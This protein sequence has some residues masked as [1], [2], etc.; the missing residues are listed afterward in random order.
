MLPLIALAGVIGAV[1]SVAKGAAWA[2]DQVDSTKGAASVGGKGGAKTQIDAKS[3]PFADALAAQ[4]AGQS[5][6]ASPAATPM[7]INL[8]PSQ[9]TDYDALARMQAGL[10]A[11]NHIGAH[12]GDHPKPA[13][14]S[15]G[16]AIGHT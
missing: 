9:G 16:V 11:Y 6:P 3:A 10:A 13:D 14:N 5:M 15:D 12:H 2:S 4:V 7:P 1:M 8:P